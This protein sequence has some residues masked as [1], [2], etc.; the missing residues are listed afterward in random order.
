MN[1]MMQIKRIKKQ[2][3][4]NEGIAFN[5]ETEISKETETVLRG[6]TVNC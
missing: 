4:A 1:K 2:L 3:T 6:A 5:T